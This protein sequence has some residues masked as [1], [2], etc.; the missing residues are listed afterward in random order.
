MPDSFTRITLSPLA[1]SEVSPA[2]VGPVCWQRSR[3]PRA[4][5]S[6]FQ[7]G[8][9][10][11]APT[12]QDYQQWPACIQTC[13]LHSSSSRRSPQ[14]PRVQSG[15]CSVYQLS[16]LSCV[17]CCAS[18]TDVC[19]LPEGNYG[20]EASEYAALISLQHCRTPFVCSAKMAAWPL[21][22]YPTPNYQLSFLIY[23]SLASPVS[24]CGPSVSCHL[25]QE[26]PILLSITA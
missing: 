8:R 3:W 14:L 12:P 11:R 13:T 16:N 24:Q 9:R 4:A 1:A 10:P 6:F 18:S 2:T 15:L 17:L 20:S 25:H 22:S 23:C 21:A 5:A 7:T 26:S 19:Q